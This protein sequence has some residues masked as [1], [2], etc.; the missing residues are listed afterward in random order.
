[1]LGRNKKYLGYAAGYAQTVVPASSLL[2]QFPS[3]LRPA[4]SP[5]AT[6][7]NK[8]Y[9]RKTASF[10]DPEIK[11]RLADIKR[12][13]NDPEEKATADE[14]ND[15][16]QWLIRY[17]QEKLPASELSPRILAGRLL[18]LNFA[19]IHTSTFSITNVIFD[20]VSADPSLNYLGQLREE[21]AT[22]LAEDNGVWTKRGLSKMHKID[23]ALRDSLRVRS[24][25]SLGLVRLV[26][27][28]EGVTAPN[29]TYCPY[30]STVAIAAYGVHNDESILPEAT[31]FNALR[32]VDARDAVPAD[33]VTGKLERDGIIK[34]ANYGL[35]STSADYQPFGHG[36]HACPGRFFAANELKL[37]LAYMVLNYDI[38]VQEKRP[39][40]RWVAQVALP[41]MTATIRV[42][43]R[44]VAET[45]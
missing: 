26:T 37:L 16:L 29:G 13:S 10:L 18:A 6:L 42:R 22:V 23:S 11:R 8:Y 33:A 43:R 2:R 17:A 12:K 35:V 25:L 7:P 41:P 9:I 28:R 36:R 4:V 24:F 15:F 27:A 45:S 44:K 39:E 5:I 21:A 32:Y 31:T 14:P 34:R 1:M 20:L 40:G 19:A 38:E 30:G 3:S